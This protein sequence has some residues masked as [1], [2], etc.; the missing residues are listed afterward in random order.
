MNLKQIIEGEVI[1]FP[2]KADSEAPIRFK[3]LNGV[4]DIKHQDVANKIKT[5]LEGSHRSYI[6]EI[7]RGGNLHGYMASHYHRDAGQNEYEL[8]SAFDTTGKRLSV[9]RVGLEELK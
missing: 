1:A 9:E 7:H 5:A 3:Q 2:S 6:H 8:H 4:Q